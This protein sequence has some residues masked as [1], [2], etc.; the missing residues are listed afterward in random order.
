MST[1]TS[2]ERMWAMLA[3]LDAAEARFTERLTASAQRNGISREE[4]Q[5]AI[6]EMRERIAVMRRELLST[7][8]SIRVH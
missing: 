1:G 8:D 4:L 3:K 2:R 5:D 6:A 7:L